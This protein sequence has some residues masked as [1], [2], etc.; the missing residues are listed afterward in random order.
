[1]GW[2]RRRRLS[3]DQ[4]EATPGV[5][6]GLADFLVHATERDAL[7]QAIDARALA[8]RGDE[9]PREASTEEVG[10]ERRLEL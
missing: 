3:A 8:L 6:S 5:A 7:R 2:L 4:R 1:M 10:D 9:A